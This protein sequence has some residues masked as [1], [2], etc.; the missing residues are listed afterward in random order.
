MKRPVA[1][2]M[3]MLAVTVLSCVHVPKQAPDLSLALSERMQ[4]VK[5]A[6]VQ[7]VRLYM[8]AKRADVDSFILREWLPTFAKNAF[9]VAAVQRAYEQACKSNSA[10]ERL[11]L[12]VGLGARLQMQLNQKRTELMQPLDAFESALMRS[13]EESYNEMLAINATLTGLLRAHAETTETQTEILQKLKVD[14]KLASAT[15]D[16]D[17]LVAML[18]A[19]RD[20]FEKN[21]PKIDEILKTLKGK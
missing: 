15:A 1:L 3:V 12:F 17:K 2:S 6:H 20:S 14:D 18:I 8:A 19:D 7:S 11:E 13:I 4:A 10:A 9:E 21:K 16:A 5:A